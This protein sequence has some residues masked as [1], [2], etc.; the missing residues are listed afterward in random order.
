[1]LVIVYTVTGS[2]LV[3]QTV[4]AA[5]D[6]RP[7]ETEAQQAARVA[8][9]DLPPGATNVQ[10]VDSAALPQSKRWR[11]AWQLGAGAVTV[12]FAGARAARRAELALLQSRRLADLTNQIDQATDNNQIA[13]V[14]SLRTKRKAVRDLDLQAVVNSVP[15]LTTLDTFVPTE[16]Q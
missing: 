9:R 1:M 8:A 7:G 16:L 2:N 5:A 3:W 10:V 4:P 13:L 12:S 6:R 11:A 15:D 14:T